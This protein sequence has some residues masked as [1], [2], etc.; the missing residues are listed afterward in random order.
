MAA[1]LLLALALLWQG[2]AAAGGAAWA[3]DGQLTVLVRILGPADQSSF[4][5]TGEYRTIWSGEVVVP[6]EATVTAYS[7]EQY[8]LYVEGGRYLSE[9]LRDGRIS[10]LG[11]GDDAL[12]ATSV[13]AALH[14]ASIQGGFS[15][16]LNDAYFPSPGLFLSGVEGYIGS[17]S[18]G[19]SYRVWSGDA[20][21][22]PS[23]SIDGFLLGYSSMVPAAPHPQVVFFWG[24]GVNCRILRVMPEADVVQ[25]G[26]PVRVGVECFA[27]I[28]YA[29]EGTWEPVPNALVC[30]GEECCATANDGFAEVRFEATGDFALVAS[31]GCDGDH[32]YIPSDGSAVVTVDGTCQVVAF[33][34]VDHGATGLDF[35]LATCGVVGQPEA[36]QTAEHGAV[37]LEVGAESTVDCKLQVRTS[38]NVQ[39]AGGVALPEEAFSWNT[40]PEVSTATPMTSEYVTVGA[41]DAGSSTRLD[42]WH[43][44]SVPADQPPTAYSGAFCY[45]AVPSGLQ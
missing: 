12:G 35:G 40:E 22:C 13:L 11:A 15:Y 31:A 18:V 2:L 39:S 23:K 5:N 43:W 6:R 32:Y 34:I 44:L 3:A 14:Q 8:R 26:E 29:G 17:G 16:R 45:R 36:G 25:C 38:A 24:Y 10:D 27:D 41:S 30:L 21:P 7:G 20:V 42:V 33:T 9:R 19:W 4:R 37:T 28:G 1:V